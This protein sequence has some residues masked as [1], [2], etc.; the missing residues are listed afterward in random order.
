MYGILT[1][2]DIPFQEI[3]TRS[4]GVNV[5]VNYNSLARLQIWAV[6]T[7]LAVTEGILVSFFSSAY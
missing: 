2:Y 5:S 1:L 3:F 6:P 4:A 7:S